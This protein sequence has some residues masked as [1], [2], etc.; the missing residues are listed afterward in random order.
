MGVGFAVAR[1]GL[2]LREFRTTQSHLPAH[3]SGLSQWSGVGLVV[4]G[5]LVNVSATARHIQL[6]REL[7]SGTWV[8]G[9]VSPNAVVLAM[10]LAAIGLAMAGYL[11]FAH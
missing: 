3:S 8:A 9:R 5:V 2:F 10:L 1:F 7:S 11:V 4:V 6:V